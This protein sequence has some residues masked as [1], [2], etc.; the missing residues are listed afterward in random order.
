MS[1]DPCDMIQPVYVDMWMSSVYLLEGK[2]SSWLRQN[3]ID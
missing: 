1:C 2:Y 3:Q